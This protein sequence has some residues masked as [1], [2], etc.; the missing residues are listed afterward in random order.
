LSWFRDRVCN[1]ILYFF[2]ENKSEKIIRNFLYK[3]NAGNGKLTADEVLLHRN[4]NHDDESHDEWIE[5]TDTDSWIKLGLSGQSTAFS[6]YYSLPSKPVNMLIITFTIDG[7]VLLGIETE[8]NKK[9]LEFSKKL[10]KTVKA[11][12][13]ANPAALFVEEAPLFSKDLFVDAINKRAIYTETGN[14]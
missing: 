12:F 11:E 5:I 14:V 4:G 7:G 13:N 6:I 8:E 1:Y 3:F 2:C 10:L 9:N